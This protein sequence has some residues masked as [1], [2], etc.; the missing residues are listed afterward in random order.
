MGAYP[1]CGFFFVVRKCN[2]RLQGHFSEYST[3]NKITTR[4]S[5]KEINEKYERS[6]MFVVSRSTYDVKYVKSMPVGQFMDLYT[7]IEK[8]VKSE[9]QRAKLSK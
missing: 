8:D 9:A 5:D 4:L 7:L 1:G 3:G 6:I 2:T